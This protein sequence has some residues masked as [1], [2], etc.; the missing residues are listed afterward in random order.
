METN[1]SAS[2]T[3]LNESHI[4]LLEDEGKDSNAKKEEKIEMESKND[5]D[6]DEK[7]TS[8]DKKA[9][10]EKKPKEKKVGP[11]KTPL[12]CAQNCT[13][14]LNVLDRDEKHINDHININ[15]EDIIAETD[16]LHGFEFIWRV[17][18]L[19][20]NNSRNW[21]YGL[22]TAI[23]APFLA[24]FWALIFSVFSAAM[25][26]ILMPLFKLFELTLHYAHKY[27]NAVVR[28]LLDPVFAA[29]GL[30]FGNIRTRTENHNH[31]HHSV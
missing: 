6:K 22:I 23:L 19:I 2:K 27:W 10:K 1:K 8:E 5:G 25:V 4:P 31:S 15:F 9:K 3:N 13:I 30:L 29:G 12:T 17:T 21:F 28:C 26:W 24:I 14:G 7:P 11:K 20:F 18:Y 16:S